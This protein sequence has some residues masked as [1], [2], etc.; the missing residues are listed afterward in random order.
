M[1]K[2]VFLRYAGIFALAVFIGSI[3]IGMIINF[4]PRVALPLSIVWGTVVALAI[5]FSCFFANRK[6][7]EEEKKSKELLS[8]VVHDLR[9]PMTTI[10][11]YTESILLGVVP[12]DKWNHCLEVILSE[13]KR[14]SG[15][16]NS[17]LDASHNKKPDCSDFD[18]CE[19]ARQVLISFEK[20]I[21]EKS[22]EVDFEGDRIFVYADRSAI[23]QVMY[24]I[25]DNAIKFSKENGKLVLSI[26]YN[27]KDKAEISVY[28]EGIGILKEDIPRVFD[29][30]FKSG[31]GTSGLGLGMHITKDI[32]D[33]HSETIK[34]DSE[35]GE[36]CRFTF[37]LAL[38]KDNSV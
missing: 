38:S 36:W 5:I 30:F 35:A 19:L 8:N 10:S 28:N 11:G 1:F 6:I 25:C 12:P 31:E 27:E 14:L 3:V 13:T 26:A 20:R 4:F 18:V 17:L 22:L 23:Y 34:V 15:L 32:I 9:S 2:K 33:A 29:R 7:K 16:V 21:E 37:T 24:N